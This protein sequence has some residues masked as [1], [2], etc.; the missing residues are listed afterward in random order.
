MKWS[1]KD[2]IKNTLENV[3]KS[4]ID[5]DNDGVLESASVGI[6][7]ES[8]PGTIA[9]VSGEC[10]GPLDALPT[11]D[12]VTDLRIGESGAKGEGLDVDGICK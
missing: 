6:V 11:V 4:D 9:V 10:E 8:L 5:A 7:V 12:R 1:S 2:A 3:I